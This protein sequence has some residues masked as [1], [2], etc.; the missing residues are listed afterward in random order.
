MVRSAFSA[1]I[2]LVLSRPNHAR[3]EVVWLRTVIGLG[4]ALRVRIGQGG[5]DHRYMLRSM[6]GRALHLSSFSSILSIGVMPFNGVMPFHSPSF[7][8]GFDTSL[9][10]SPQGVLRV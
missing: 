7:I 9:L 3:F 1:S 2:H 10:V 8:M 4:F 5:R 6:R